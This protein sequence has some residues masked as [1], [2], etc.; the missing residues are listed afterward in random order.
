MQR[1]RQGIPVVLQKAK[2][3]LHGSATT[4]VRLTVVV[5]PAELVTV[6]KTMKGLVPVGWLLSITLPSARGMIIKNSL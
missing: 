1:L 2:G 6:Y 3:V 5:S 4:T